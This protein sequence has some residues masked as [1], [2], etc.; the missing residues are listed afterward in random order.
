MEKIGYAKTLPKGH[1]ISK[2]GEVPSL[3]YVIKKGRVIA[4]EVTP[5]GGERVFYMMEENSLLLEAN[6]FLRIPAFV[7]FKTSMPTE[8]ICI[9]RES[10]L[11]AIAGDAQMAFDIIE[12]ISNKFLSSID[13]M[14]QN[15]GQSS[16]WK[17]SNLLLIFADRFGVPY[18]GK[19]LIKE[20]ISQ[21]MIANLLGINRV[22]ATRIM[23]ELRDLVLIEQV[24]G[25]YCIRDIEKLKL[26]MEHI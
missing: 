8:L 21:Q 19:I 6:L 10:L 18:D 15:Y 5:S 13:Q 16:K 17:I 25:Y 9:S 23:K 12:S 14:R 20:K 4:F 2:P 24:N 11:L 26:H 7:Y 22:T 1:I 3:C